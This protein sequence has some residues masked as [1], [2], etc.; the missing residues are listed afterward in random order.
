MEK[1]PAGH[2]DTSRY[3]LGSTPFFSRG[4]CPPGSLLEFIRSSSYPWSLS[5]STSSLQAPLSSRTGR[6]ES[7]NSPSAGPVPLHSVLS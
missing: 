1:E 5:S 2:P 6:G 7:P 3:P 4:N